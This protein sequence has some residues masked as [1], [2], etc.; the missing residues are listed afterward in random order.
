MS[1]NSDKTDCRSPYARRINRQT[2]AQR[3]R[4]AHYGSAFPLG[5]LP[6]PFRTPFRTSPKHSKGLY[7]RPFLTSRPAPFRTPVPLL[8][9]SDM[10]LRVRSDQMEDRRYEGEF[11]K[12]WRLEPGARTFSPQ[13]RPNVYRPRS[14][15][16]LLRTKVRGPHHLT[17][18]LIH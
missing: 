12:R 13:Q 11:E 17:N 4:M 2:N 6:S 10:K 3:R 15:R 5:P 8:G 18:S 14:V 1:L 9:A 16:A 7:P